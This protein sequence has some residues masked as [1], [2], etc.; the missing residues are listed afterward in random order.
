[1]YHI[2]VN[3]MLEKKRKFNKIYIRKKIPSHCVLRNSGGSGHK[4]FSLVKHSSSIFP[5]GT[6]AN[7]R[8]C[9][10]IRLAYKA[11]PL[12]RPPPLTG[13]SIASRSGTCSRNST[14][15]VP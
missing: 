1:M 9:G 11:I 3:D 7:I 10:L 15:I 12:I 4:R 6:Q 13:T 14:A 2:V 8:I 5:S